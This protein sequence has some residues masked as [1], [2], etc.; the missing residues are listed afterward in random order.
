MFVF[1]LVLVRIVVNRKM[2][3]KTQY[4][5]YYFLAHVSRRWDQQGI[6]KKSAE[7]K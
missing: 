6:T 1:E 3:T 5:I 4:S 2:N 7:L